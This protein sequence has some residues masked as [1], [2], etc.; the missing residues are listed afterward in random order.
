MARAASPASPRALLIAAACFFGSS[1][2]TM[3]WTGVTL[4]I[5]A[6]T[7]F[8]ADLTILPWLVERFERPLRRRETS[9][10]LAYPK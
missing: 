6:V 4:G 7:A 9:I 8:L 3:R 1:F 10:L 2:T 5:V